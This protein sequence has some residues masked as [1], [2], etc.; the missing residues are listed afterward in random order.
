MTDGVQ[1]ER[2]LPA[3][4]AL[5]T[6]LYQLTMLSVY[7][8]KDMRQTAV[9][10]FFVRK[11][12]RQ[13]NFL[14]AAGLEQVLQY[15]ESLKFTPGELEWLARSGHFDAD[16]IDELASLEFTGDVHALPEGTVFFADEPVLRVTAPLPEAQ[17]VESRIINILQFQTMVAS[18][19]ARCVLAAP[20]KMLVDFGMRRAHGAEAA[21]LAARAAYVAGFTGT[22]TVQ[23]AQYFH[24]PCF[25]T[26]AHSFV[27][28]H[29]EEVEAF[30][31]FA[32]NRPGNVVLLIDTYDTQRGAERAAEL[33]RRLA[34]E[35]IRIRAVRI[36]SGELGEEARMV[37]AILDRQGC[38]DMTI[39]A[40]G[41]L[42]E[43]RIAAMLAKGAPVDGFGIGTRLDASTDAPTLD[44]AYKLQEYAGIARRKR[45][46]GKQTWPGRKQLFRQFDAWGKLHEDLLGLQ[47]ESH[48]GQALLQPFMHQGRR[49]A[50][51]E[52]LDSIRTRSAGSLRS[53]PAALQDLAAEHQFSV[54]ISKR[55]QELTQQVDRQFG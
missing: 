35:G 39:F 25:G 21:L 32:R 10:E 54:R 41:N 13:R 37:R 38:S 24:M 30:E 7:F 11:L 6:D 26:M 5:L 19:A 17:L 18:K 52:T 33:S 12:P 20:E 49:I 44:C 36:D 23:A 8:R 40:S 22:A 46:P 2:P 3:T 51:A 28:A 42:D 31:A 45:S 48:P 53:L 29:D 43:H 14:L 55:L 34:G 15:L 27:Q 4:S 50:A 9:F 47:H 1:T 16:F